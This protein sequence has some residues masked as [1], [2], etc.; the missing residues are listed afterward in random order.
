MLVCDF[1]G[2][3]KSIFQVVLAFW[4]VFY[5]GNGNSF[6]LERGIVYSGGK[7][8]VYPCC[9]PVS[10]Y[11]RCCVLAIE[12]KN[13]IFILIPKISISCNIHRHDDSFRCFLR[14]WICRK[15]RSLVCK[16]IISYNSIK[17][18]VSNNKF[19]KKQ[20]SS[21]GRAWVL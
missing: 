20:Q 8:S 1:L 18:S 16:Y 17:K 21:V 13:W 7:K 3:F 11:R 6:I 9:V 10:T 2:D 15:G 12:G 4:L 5:L 14:S 19:L